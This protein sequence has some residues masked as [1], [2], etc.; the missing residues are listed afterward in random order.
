ME[1]STV[2]CSKASECSVVVT[3]HCYDQ[4]EGKRD[5]FCD[6]FYYYG[7]TGEKC[8][9]PTSTVYFTRVTLIITLLWAV[10]LF[11]LT[12]R[13]L[14]ANVYLGSNPE[15]G[16]DP[17][18]YA[19]L[20]IILSCFS[21][22]LFLISHLISNFAPN[23]YVVYDDGEL[24]IVGPFGGIFSQ[25]AYLFFVFFIVF[26]V[27]SMILSWQKVYQKVSVFVSKS[28]LKRNTSETITTWFFRIV[29]IVFVVL[30][31]FQQF[32]FAF[33]MLVGCG[34]VTGVLFF[35]HA[36]NF[37]K[38][39][40]M[41]DQSRSKQVTLT[42]DLIEKL[43]FF[44]TVG[45]VLTVIS[46]IFFRVTF[47]FL[48]KTAIPGDFSYSVVFR[49][50]ANVTGLMLLTGFSWYGNSTT[51]G[52]VLSDNV[53]CCSI[54]S[55]WDAKNKKVFPE[56]LSPEETLTQTQIEIKMSS[57]NQSN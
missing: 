18:N 4:I 56:K 42:L 9:S 48:N 2:E 6:C 41:L 19:L 34:F 44:T 46:Y 29:F 37:K 12:T 14:L 16:V 15:K 53:K 55:F 40:L 51:E 54:F 5:A 11:I 26:S 32:T 35:L 13:T 8:D 24:E 20:C 23:T 36:K 52:A 31:G 1:N 57:T 17:V 27:R 25:F 47:D 30:C 38:L 33:I 45:V 43:S 7:Y 49:E 10:L 22:I 3:K 28:T 39:V 50:L 21:L